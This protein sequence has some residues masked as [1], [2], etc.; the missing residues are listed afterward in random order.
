MSS[1][2]I[3]FSQLPIELLHQINKYWSPR[4]LLCFY[5]ALGE[6]PGGEELQLSLKKIYS[7]MLS[8][9]Y[10]SAS[11]R[12]GPNTYYWDILIDFCSPCHPPSIIQE[13]SLR[14]KTFG[15]PYTRRIR[16][17]LLPLSREMLE[18]QR[19]IPRILNALSRTCS[20]KS[21]RSC[22]N[23]YTTQPSFLCLT[24]GALCGGAHEL[25]SDHM[26]ACRKFLNY[27]FSLMEKKNVSFD[28]QD[29][30]RLLSKVL[31]FSGSFEAFQYLL[32]EMKKRGPNVRPNVKAE[33]YQKL[34]P[35]AVQHADNRTLVFLL[36]FA[37]ETNDEILLRCICNGS[38]E[39]TKIFASKGDVYR[40]YTYLLYQAAKFGRLEIFQEAVKFLLEARSGEGFSLT[41][42]TKV[43][44]KCLKYGRLDILRYIH[45]KGWDINLCPM[46]S[47]T[48]KERKLSMEFIRYVF[49]VTDYTLTIRQEE[50]GKFMLGLVAN[51]RQ[52]IEYVFEQ[53]NLA[54]TRTCWS[55]DDRRGEENGDQRVEW[56]TQPYILRCMER[57]LAHGNLEGYIFFREK[58][59]GN[60][61]SEL[62]RNLLYQAIRSTNPDCFFALRSEFRTYFPLSSPE[63]LEIEKDLITLVTSIGC[64]YHILQRLLDEAEQET[65]NQA[66]LTLA[67]SGAN[68]SRQFEIFDFYASNQEEVMKVMEPKIQAHF[69]GLETFY[70][71]H[72]T[73]TSTQRAQNMGAR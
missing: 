70:R 27:L 11:D 55:G 20:V 37:P 7:C 58:Y 44:R 69:Q 23:M 57:C 51:N 8:R 53:F 30:Q 17:N 63:N 31:K 22:G 18:N 52:I 54:H 3:L 15:T 71:A 66:Y 5:L 56:L 33:L 42:M 14:K 50:A 21:F 9:E 4:T 12:Y 36:P 43:C 40:N 73:L 16:K 19:N 49:E 28:L 61:S 24:M 46:A 72:I 64:A 45:D 48:T 68:F 1:L 2:L 67:M 10:I 29:W 13:G 35:K 62:C 34:F 41:V 26:S 38:V 65:V 60:F 32:M 39:R 47:W 6:I 25:H 59:T